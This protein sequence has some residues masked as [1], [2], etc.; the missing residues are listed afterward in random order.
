MGAAYRKP[1]W[2]KAV[3][4]MLLQY[5]NAKKMID[6]NVVQLFPSL[7]NS[8]SERVKGGKSTSSTERYGIK[9]AEQK[10]LVSTIEYALSFLTDDEREVIEES[11]FVNHRLPIDIVCERFGWSRR[12]LLYLKQSALEKIAN[13][14]NLN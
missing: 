14:L 3:E 10:K 13:T 5:P 2:R 1:E 12:K 11:Y 9:R 6:N 8:Y 7:I 4:L